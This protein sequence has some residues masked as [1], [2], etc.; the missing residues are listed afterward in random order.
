MADDKKEFEPQYIVNE[1]G[2]VRLSKDQEDF[3]GAIKD[4]KWSV[5]EGSMPNGAKWNTEDNLEI[6]KAQVQ[7]LK[8]NAELDGK[9]AKV[10]ADA[11]DKAAKEAEANKA[12]EPKAPI[13]PDYVVAVVPHPDTLDAAGKPTQP[14]GQPTPAPQQYQPAQPSA[15]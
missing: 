9:K 2:S 10:K 15:R 7:V 8:D 1:S 14:T 6:R 4:G 13:Q 3:D 5:A 12:K 11:A